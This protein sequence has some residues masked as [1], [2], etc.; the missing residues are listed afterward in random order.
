[1]FPF[2]VLVDESADRMK[3]AV[4]NAT[5]EGDLRDSPVEEVHDCETTAN[6]ETA[7]TPVQHMQEGT[8]LVDIHT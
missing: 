8:A 6:A 1:M 5:L 2:A 4:N 3:H 7:T